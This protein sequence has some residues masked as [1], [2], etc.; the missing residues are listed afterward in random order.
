MSATQTIKR[1]IRRKFLASGMSVAEF[2]RQLGVHHNEAYR[3]LDVSHAT[4]LPRMEDALAVFDS[5]L[6]ISEKEMRQ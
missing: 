6:V 4:K 3:V 2:A 5:R 1:I